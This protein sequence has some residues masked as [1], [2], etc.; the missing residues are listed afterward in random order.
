MLAMLVTKSLAPRCRHIKCERSVGYILCQTA[1]HN[2]PNVGTTS[3]IA[4]AAEAG[5]PAPIAQTGS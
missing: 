2:Q 5:R 1:L 3:A 4:A